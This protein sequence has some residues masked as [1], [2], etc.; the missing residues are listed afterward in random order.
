MLG[1]ID[2][3]LGGLLSRKVLTLLLVADAVD[4]LA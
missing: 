3:T 1:D 4:A 2:V